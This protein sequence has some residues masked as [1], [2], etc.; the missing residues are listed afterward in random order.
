[1]AVDLA[2]ILKLIEEGIALEKKIESAIASE[3]DINRRKKLLKAIQ[4]RDLETIRE[5]LF[6]VQ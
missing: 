3:K 2:T 1:M 5:L 4:E 6:T